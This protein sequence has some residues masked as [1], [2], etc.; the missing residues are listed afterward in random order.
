MYEGVPIE[1][2]K[3]EKRKEKNSVKIEVRKRLN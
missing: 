3:E 1:G 2:Q